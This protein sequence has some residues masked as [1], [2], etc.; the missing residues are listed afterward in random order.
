MDHDA[1]PLPMLEFKENIVDPDTEADF[2]GPDIYHCL[3]VP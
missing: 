3:D 1:L 2:S